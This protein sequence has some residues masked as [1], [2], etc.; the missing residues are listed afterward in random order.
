MKQV[1]IEKA[2]PKLGDIVD[3]ARLTGRATV[4]TRHGEPAATVAPIIRDGD[5]RDIAEARVLAERAGLDSETGG[6]ISNLLD[7]IGR[8]TADL[9]EETAVHLERM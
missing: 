4:I 8:L 2:R 9:H 1:S 3:R 7:I 6:A 5:L